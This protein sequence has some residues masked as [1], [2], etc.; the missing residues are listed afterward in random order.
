MPNLFNPEAAP[1]MTPN[2]WREFQMEVLRERRTQLAE[3]RQASP[4][5][6][7]TH[8]AFLEQAITVAEERLG[9]GAV[10]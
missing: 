7:S 1:R 6:V 3:M 2:Q 4:N 9:L 5:Y 10:A 8:M